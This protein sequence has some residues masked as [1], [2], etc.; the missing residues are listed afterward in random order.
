M[1]LT[2][3]RRRIQKFAQLCTKTRNRGGELPGRVHWFSPVNYSSKP[4][5]NQNPG[6]D[7]HKKPTKTPEESFKLGPSILPI[8][9]SEPRAIRSTLQRFPLWPNLLFTK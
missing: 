8:H 7:I 9:Q 4:A 5:V 1:F 6:F 3:K 2:K